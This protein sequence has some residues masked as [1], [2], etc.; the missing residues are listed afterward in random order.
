MAGHV[1]D[2]GGSKFHLKIWLR[3]WFVFFFSFSAPSF[4][5]N[6][7]IGRNQEIAS[8]WSTGSRKSWGVKGSW[9]IE[10]RPAL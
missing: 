3:N 8:C 6:E 4:L 10:R 5:I 9:V 2:F 7:I 1:C